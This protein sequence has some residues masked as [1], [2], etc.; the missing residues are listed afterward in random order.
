MRYIAIV[1]TWNDGS[2]DYVSVLDNGLSTV[3]YMGGELSPLWLKERAALLRL[4]EVN[5]SAKGETFGR[6][7]SDNMMHVYLDKQEYKQLSNLIATGAREDENQ[8]P[9]QER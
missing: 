5:R 1:H 8:K 6:R 4:C 9:S 2:I 7:F 3:E